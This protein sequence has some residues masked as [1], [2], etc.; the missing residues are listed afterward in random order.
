MGT[1]TRWLLVTAVAAVAVY[2]A[3]WIGYAMRWPWLDGLDTTGLAI[4]YRY[5]SAHP[6]WVIAWNVFCEVLGPFAFRLLALVLI[7]VALV[8]RRRRLALF[9]LL[10][11]EL[12]AVVTEVAKAL[13]NRPRPDT[14]L[15]HALSSSFP[16]GHA[17]GVMVAVLALT[18]LVWPTLHP[19]LRKWWAAV[20]VLI[21][22]AIGVGRVVLN[23]HHPSDVVAG[24]A[25]GYVWF[26]AVFL[27]CPPS[28][29]VTTVD[30]TPEAL[31]S[32]R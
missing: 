20:G 16:S 17:V 11:I 28:A 19:P 12:S 21:V 7:V 9:L 2:A 1:R 26:V 32:A 31:G 27:I 5:L 14:A 18:V 22:V 23:V 24:W 6:A 10:T 25:L 30:E 13:V 4:P 29:P 8:R 15:V 3:L